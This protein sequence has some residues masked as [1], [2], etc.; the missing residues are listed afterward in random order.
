MTAIDLRFGPMAPPLHTQI[1]M[2]AAELLH[3]Q[4]DADAVVRLRSRGIL[5]RGAA[6]RA[7][8]RIAEAVRDLISGRPHIPPSGTNGAA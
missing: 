8:Y 2:S 1:G 5:S 6:D 4:W 3:L 7:N